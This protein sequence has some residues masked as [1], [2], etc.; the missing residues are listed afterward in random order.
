MK[1][2]DKASW[3]E[4][5]VGASGMLGAKAMAS[6]K[7]TAI[8]SARFRISVTRTAARH[9]RTGPAE[10]LHLP[11]PVRRAGVRDHQC[12]R[13]HRGRRSTNSSPMP[14]NPGAVTHAHAGVGGCHPCWHGGIRAG[15]ERTDSSA[16][17]VQGGAEAL[18]ATDRRPC[19]CTGGLQLLGATSNPAIGCSPPGARRGCRASGDARHAEGRRLQRGGRCAQRHRRAERLD[20]AITKNSATR[21]A[22]RWQPEFKSACDKIDA[23]VLPPDGP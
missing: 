23:P 14:A 21:S 19:R 20:P 15:G 8:P 10:R 12:R 5:R 18:Q 3:W 22:L 16:T 2:P 4:N 7:W 13:T 17:S 11:Q 6:A 9:H 1:V